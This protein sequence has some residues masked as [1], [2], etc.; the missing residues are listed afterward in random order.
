[1]NG[2]RR[3]AMAEL[4]RAGRYAS[5]DP[6]TCSACDG[7]IE[8][9]CILTGPAGSGGIIY[10]ECGCGS[11][12]WANEEHCGRW[13]RYYYTAGPAIEIVGDDYDCHAP[14]DNWR[15]HLYVDPESRRI[16]FDRQ[17]GDGTPMRVWHGRAVRLRLPRGAVGE[18]VSRVLQTDACQELLAEL[19]DRYEGT[20]WDGSNHVGVWAGDADGVE[21]FGLEERIEELFADVPTYWDAGD[22]LSPVWG[23]DEADTVRARLSSESLDSVVDEMVAD[24]RINEAWVHSGDLRDALERLLEEHP[25]A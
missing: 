18:E 21:R 3:K 14:N 8:W 24:A 5:T 13:D 22:W 23:Q 15:H 6:V 19:C 11:R 25:A 16:S 20:E 17:F 7:T 4:T 12:A 1:M 10:G 9:G 2:E